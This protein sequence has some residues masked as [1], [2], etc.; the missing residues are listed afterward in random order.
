MS[1]HYKLTP[2]E[3]ELMEEVDAYLWR[4]NCIPVDVYMYS[5]EYAKHLGITE[6]RAKELAYMVI[7]GKVARAH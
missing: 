6:S 3:R 7:E 5:V 4:R 2:N 1:I